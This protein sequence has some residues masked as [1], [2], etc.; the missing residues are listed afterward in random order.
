[1][2]DLDRLGDFAKDQPKDGDLVL[3]CGH[4][5]YTSQGHFWKG[6]ISFTRP[7]G[8]VGKAQWV[9]ACPECF[10]E[11]KGSVDNLV[12]LGE[13]TWVGDDPLIREDG[14]TRERN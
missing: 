14:F 10:R 1:M 12:L 5:P 4:V 11:S 13:D 6:N 7:D 8:S 3:H 9:I 2:N